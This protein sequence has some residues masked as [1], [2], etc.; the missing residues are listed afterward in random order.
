MAKELLQGGP[1]LGDP[2]KSTLTY[3]PEMM[4][5]NG[6]DRQAS[7]HTEE[8]Q[9]E[10]PHGGQQPLATDDPASAGNQSGAEDEE[11][12]DTGVIHSWTVSALNFGPDR[13][14]GESIYARNLFNL[15]CFVGLCMEA[16]ELHVQELIKPRKDEMEWKPAV[17]PLSLQ[18]PVQGYLEDPCVGGDP[19]RYAQRWRT[20]PIYGGLCVAGRLGRVKELTIVDQW[21]VS[22]K[23]GQSKMMVV[24]VMW[25]MPVDGKPGT[26][27]CVGH[28]HNLLAKTT[29]TIEVGQWWDKLAQ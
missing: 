22:Y 27:V 8:A 2:T 1:A 7:T 28:M 9:E 10:Q 13:K 19:K 25:Q 12:D 14:V 6:W 26:R 4:R 29:Q 15:P 11:E 16:T 23:N 21:S 5:A 17:D 24:D 18:E 3:G 20:T